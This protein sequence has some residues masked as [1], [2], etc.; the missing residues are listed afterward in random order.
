M[1]TKTLLKALS[2]LDQKNISGGGRIARD[3]PPPPPPQPWF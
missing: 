3:P 1:K 2:A